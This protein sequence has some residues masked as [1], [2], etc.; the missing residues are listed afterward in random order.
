MRDTAETLVT[1]IAAT[2]DLVTRP[3]HGLSYDVE[4]E[5]A[6]K[7]RKMSVHSYS[8]ATPSGTYN[9]KI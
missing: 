1:A 7:R 4:E 5:H 6:A 8:S 2:R 9:P 3:H